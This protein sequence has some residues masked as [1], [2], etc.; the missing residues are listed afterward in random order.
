M[1]GIV[2]REAHALDLEAIVR[3][4]EADT[5]GGHA[6][7]WNDDTQ[8]GYAAAFAAIA[9]SPDNALFVACDGNEVVGVFQVVL[10]HSITDRGRP[11]VK[12]EGV[13]VRTDQRSKGVGA[14]MMT[15]ADAWARERG[16][17]FVE[18]G[19]NKKRTDAHRFYVRHGYANSHEGFKKLL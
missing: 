16:A 6:D 12:V 19:S 11:R 5:L 18:L 4:H 1:N 3:L 9:A 7:V 15:H 14:L 13:Q 8:A 17:I 10:L 2:V